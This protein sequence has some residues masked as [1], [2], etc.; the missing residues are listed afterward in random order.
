MK[1]IL[2]SGARGFIGGYLKNN[3]ENLGYNI[4]TFDRSEFDKIYNNKG[5]WREQV[6]VDVV[7]HCAANPNI[8]ETDKPEEIWESN[9]T[10][11]HKLIESVIGTPKFINLSSVAVYGAKPNDHQDWQ[12]TEYNN[13]NPLSTYG[14]TKLASEFLVNKYTD[15]YKIAGINLRLGGV[16]GPHMTHGIL[17]KIIN[18]FKNDTEIE[19]FEPSPGNQMSYIHVSYI[20]DLIEKLIQGD[21]F[22]DADKA[23]TLNVCSSNTLSITDIVNYFNKQL[24]KDLRIKW[25]KNYSF[26]NDNSVFLSNTKKLSQAIEVPTVEESLD[27]VINEYFGKNR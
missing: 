23:I 20:A 21:Y 17:N 4:L 6:D 1:K 24:K 22:Y 8:K 14:M 9:V 18:G 12:P 10:L 3:L 19:F 7:I 2:I 11:T 16:C 15:Q 25:I 27:R 13:T 5:V 26:K